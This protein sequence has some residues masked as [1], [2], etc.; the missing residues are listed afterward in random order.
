MSLSDFGKATTILVQQY[1]N[2]VLDFVSTE[3]LSMMYKRY[4]GDV[5]GG[6]TTVL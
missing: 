3:T 2:V 1:A 4:Q 6:Y 5:S